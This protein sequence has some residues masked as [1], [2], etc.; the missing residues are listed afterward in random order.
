MLQTLINHLTSNEYPIIII[1]DTS[2][3]GNHYLSV[4][5]QTIE[6]ERPVVYFYKMIELKNDE[7]GHGMFSPLLEEFENDEITEHMKEHITGLATD[8]AVNMRGKINGLAAYI[9]KVR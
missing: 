6:N 1:V 2:D 3:A 8:R 4:L 7:T 9:K 5:F